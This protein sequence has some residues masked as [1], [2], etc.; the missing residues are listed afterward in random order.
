MWVPDLL[1]N[2]QAGAG[3]MPF[4]FKQHPVEQFKEHVWVAPYYEDDMAMLK[5]AIGIDRLLFG[6]DF[7]HTE[8]L[9]EPDVLREGHPD[10]R[11]GRDQGHHARQRPR[12]R[13]GCS[14]PSVAIAPWPC[15]VGEGDGA[16]HEVVEAAGGLPLDDGA[17][18]GDVELEGVALDGVDDAGGHRLGRLEGAVVDGVVVAGLVPD[19]GGD[20]AGEDE[21]DVDAGVEEVHRH[22]LA[23]AAER[24]LGGAVG[25]LLHDAGAAAEAR[26]VHDHALV[27]LEHAGEHGEGHPHG[28]LEV[29]RH[30]LAHLVER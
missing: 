17:H 18:V 26:H 28:R 12:P 10:L 9:P 6:S 22:R 11:R 20:G 15:L 21:A 30:R 27:A 19:L 5:D 29:H 8:G 23:P 7:P 13:C 25:G 16:G 3:K 1:R 4:A 2:L 24:E 14:P